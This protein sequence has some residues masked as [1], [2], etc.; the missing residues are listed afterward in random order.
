MRDPVDF[1]AA[2]AHVHVLACTLY[3]MYS[4]AQK[5]GP[6]NT[7]YWTT[8]ERYQGEW[9][10]NKKHG[11][12]VGCELWLAEQRTQKFWAGGGA[13][14]GGTTTVQPFASSMESC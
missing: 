2:S 9:S 4:Q 14:G 6:R 1:L 12:A 7:V 11:G 10:D 13:R 3:P 8:G 5:Q